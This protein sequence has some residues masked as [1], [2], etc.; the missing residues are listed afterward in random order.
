MVAAFGQ[1]AQK[2]PTATPAPGPAPSTEAVV[3]GGT[4]GA[5]GGALSK[6][7]SLINP[8]VIDGVGKSIFGFFKAV[9]DSDAAITSLDPKELGINYVTER[10]IS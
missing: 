8:R 10:L 1:M 3:S 5:G 9:T 4:A 7:K 2:L 6:I